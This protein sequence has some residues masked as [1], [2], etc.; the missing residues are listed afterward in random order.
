M[1]HGSANP[2]THFA[3]FMTK[4]LLTTS[5]ALLTPDGRLEQYEQ[6]A[7]PM[8]PKL[9]L[10][11][12]L[13]IPCQALVIFCSPMACV[14]MEA[15][16]L[17]CDC[18]YPAGCRSVV[19]NGG[20]ER[21]TLATWRELVERRLT[22]HFGFAEPWPVNAQPSSIA[23]AK[24]NV[25]KAI[26]QADQPLP[27]TLDERRQK[28]STADVMLE[29]FV[30]RCHQRG[31]EVEFGGDPLTGGLVPRASGTVAYAYLE[32]ASTSPTGVLTDRC[33]KSAETLRAVGVDASAANVNVAL[34]AHPQEQRRACLTWEAQIGRRALGWCPR[35]SESDLGVSQAE[36]LLYALSE[37]RRIESGEQ[38]ALVIP[39]DFPNALLGALG[40]L[41]PLLKNLVDEILRSGSPT[42]C[43]CLALEH[44]TRDP[45]AAHATPH[46]TPRATC[47][48]SFVRSPPYPTVPSAPEHSWP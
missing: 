3:T 34:V 25:I 39:P 8:S 45:Q 46:A 19:L 17:F 31:V 33:V 20:V 27:E 32:L 23:L 28:A 13:N 22:S 30:A 24:Q 14:P 5:L 40:R 26:V 38:G 47:A 11:P 29:L 18:L 9:A 16:D 1:R 12:W 43:E 7:G 41:E 48:L 15:A 10:G 6:K 21:S 42:A 36:M 35:P 4:Q 44:T 2:F 37:L